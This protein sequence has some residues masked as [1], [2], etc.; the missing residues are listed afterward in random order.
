M[1]DEVRQSVMSTSTWTRGLFMILFALIYQMA[2]LVIILTCIFQF[3]AKLITGQPNERLLVFSE[4]VSEFI[5]QI[6]Q[7]ETFN[8]E[9]KPFPFNPWPELEDVEPVD[10]ET[11][12][13]A[14][15]G[16]DA[17]DEDSVD[18]ETDSEQTADEAPVETSNDAEEVI[19]GEVI[20]AESPDKKS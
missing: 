10:Q 20:S 2:E 6:L 4:E 8:T 1:N 9:Y 7:F 3:V 13:E 12:E 11:D 14:S 18:E 19:E 16:E 15:Y 5:L 17:I